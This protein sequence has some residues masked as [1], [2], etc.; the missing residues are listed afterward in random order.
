MCGFSRHEGIR[1]SCEHGEQLPP[2][3]AASFE[4]VWDGA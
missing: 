1:L 2:L 3:L 4:Y